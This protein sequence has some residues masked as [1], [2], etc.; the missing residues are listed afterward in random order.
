VSQFA[1]LVLGAAVSGLLSALLFG[2]VPRHRRVVRP[3][4]ADGDDRGRA[5]AVGG[6]DRRRPARRP[7]SRR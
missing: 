2:V 4:R 5:A 6:G 3:E 7:V 1:M